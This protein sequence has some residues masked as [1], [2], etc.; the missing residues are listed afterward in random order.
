MNRRIFVITMFFFV[1][2]VIAGD[3]VEVKNDYPIKS[4]PVSAVQ[5]SEGFWENRVETNRKVTIPYCLAQCEE[6]GRID[7]FA[8]AGGLKEGAHKGHYFN[9]SDVFKVIEGASYSLMIHPDAELEKYLDEIIAKI[10]TAQEDDGY[11]Y[12]ARTANP[13]NPPKQSGKERWSKLRYSHELYN[14][15]HMYEAAATHYQATGKRNLLDVATKS[16]DLLLRTFGP[17]KKR[18]TSGHEEIEIGLVRL[19][20]VTGKKDYLQLAKF[21][22]DQRG[23]HTDRESYKDFSAGP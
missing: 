15:G 9:D 11:L 22:I 4:V 18:D 19:H 1:R 12:T 2:I 20:R 17:D 5:L 7:N 13:D 10:A 8:I 14:L 21:F 23:N 16:A 3:T 6:S